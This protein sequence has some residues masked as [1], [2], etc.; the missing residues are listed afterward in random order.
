MAICAGA[1]LLLVP[2]ASRMQQE[3][4]TS[5]N[6]GSFYLLRPKDLS[7]SI[8]QIDR[9]ACFVAIHSHLYIAMQTLECSRPAAGSPRIGS[10]IHTGPFQIKSLT[11]SPTVPGL[12]RK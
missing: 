3:Q 1:N 2:E 9:T 12:E 10:A 8:Y 4:D 11:L 7:Y 6:E 5:T